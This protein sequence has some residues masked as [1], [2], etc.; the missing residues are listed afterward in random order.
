M[1]LNGI[2]KS[3]H[4]GRERKLRRDLSH[5]NKSTSYRVCHLIIRR[6][7]NLFKPYYRMLISKHAKENVLR[8][9]RGR[10]LDK[11]QE[12]RIAQE[13]FIRT[14]GHD[15]L[16]QGY[17]VVGF[18]IAHVSENYCIRKS[19]GMFTNT[20]RTNFTSGGRLR[21]W[22]PGTQQSNKHP[23]SSRQRGIKEDVPKG[24]SARNDF[25]N[26]TWENSTNRIWV[27]RTQ[28]QFKFLYQEWSST[29]AECTI[30]SGFKRS[31]E[32]TIANHFFKRNAPLNRSRA[33]CFN[34]FDN[35]ASPPQYS[36]D[37]W[38]SDRGIGS[39]ELKRI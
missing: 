39:Y 18:T 19:S 14:T 21:D 7:F 32:A 12:N 25:S 16:R 29:Y 30:F 4:P 2:A 38:K 26:V 34:R 13:R 10:L 23:N 31:N 37:K 8:R 3:K 33:S 27:L 9:V 11:L 15:L 20:K 22:T 28:L 24:R 17:R 5:I 6:R 35:F 1:L 36:V